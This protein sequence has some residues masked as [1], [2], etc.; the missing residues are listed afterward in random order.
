MNKLFYGLIIMMICNIITAT[1]Q[2]HITSVVRTDTIP[3]LNCDTAKFVI[4]TDCTNYGVWVFWGDGSN[5]DMAYI[6]PPHNYT[7]ASHAYSFPGRY[8]VKFALTNDTLMYSGVSSDSVTYD[9]ELSSPCNTPPS[10]TLPIEVFLDNNGT[11][12]YDSINDPF[13]SF[14]INIQVKRN[15]TIVD[16]VCCSSGFYY[17]CSGIPGDIYSFQIISMPYG[18]MITCPLSAVLS[19]TIGVSY[20]NYPKKYFGMKCSGTTAFDLSVYAIISVTELTDQTG[21]IYINNYSC[22]AKNSSLQMN[23]SPKYAYISATP[24]PFTHLGN[25][26]T[27]NI[28]GITARTP[29]SIYFKS[30]NS[31]PVIAH[32]TIQ[33]HFTVTP[34]T[35]D[36]DTLNNIEVVID[37]I[38]AS[39]DP[40]EMW[41]SPVDTITAGTQLRYSISFVNTGN[42]T[43]FNIS[44]Y[45]T[46]S[47]YVDV[48]SLKLLMASAKMN[49]AMKNTGGHN[50][51]KFD[52]PG[53][54]LLDSSHHDQCSGAIIFTVNSKATLPPGTK[55]YNEAGIYFDYNAVVMTNTVEN[56]IAKPTKVETINNGNTIILSPN[57]AKDELN[58]VTG[59]SDFNSLSIT[60]S[61]GLQLIQKSISL[62]NQ[63]VN[64]QSLPR[65]IYFVTLR[66]VSGIITRQFVKM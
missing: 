21:K 37:T 17:N 4:N 15:G 41:V 25:T 60:N 54:N 46:L 16:T 44:V 6:D 32:D 9:L 10:Y 22:Q 61:L 12:I 49:I 45:D 29:E 23:I 47:D 64:I 62:G 18:M 56:I 26:L 63:Q 8:T 11:G 2:Y 53:I 36:S 20:S 59:N 35:G 3:G 43:A 31:L 13:I 55:I 58:I 48:K 30:L 28:T 66:G 24:F 1:A 27:W 38:R 19:D 39:C 7:T 14:P 42:D 51:I 52:F 50:I 40:N 57:P 33:N 5:P 34:I 65:G